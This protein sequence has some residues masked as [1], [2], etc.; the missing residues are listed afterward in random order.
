[1]VTA[2]LFA[3]QPLVACAARAPLSQ[4]V[5]TSRAEPAP[6]PEPEPTSEHH[7]ARP[8]AEP[9]WPHFSAALGW[10]QAALLKTLGH[11]RY[12]AAVRLRVRVAPSAL[13]AYRDLATDAP[14][15]SGAQVAALHESPEGE[16][17]SVFVLEKG[18]GGWTALELSA[19][20]VRV[21]SDGGLC[22]RCHVLAPSDY[23][24][25]LASRSA[26]PAPSSLGLPATGPAGSPVPQP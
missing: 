5:G 26:E 20:G 4:P 10:P 6:E 12:G 16:L 18:A 24:F 21:P 19:R 8:L 11:H 17:L 7:R 3:L 22:L 1:M 23:L 14:M 9:S 2:S 25:G 15:P 13:S